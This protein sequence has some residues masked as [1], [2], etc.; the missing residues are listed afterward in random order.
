MNISPTIISTASKVK[1]RRD[2]IGTVHRL[3]V[4]QPLMAE[5]GRHRLI[6]AWP[7]GLLEIA[8]I[9]ALMATV[10]VVSCYAPWGL[11]PEP[12][13]LSPKNPGPKP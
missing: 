1:I 10:R 2:A 11:N 13:T 9:T 12:K 8:G 4:C 6:T 7:S 3:Q 5:F